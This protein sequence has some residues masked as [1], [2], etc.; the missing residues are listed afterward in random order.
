MA[1]SSGYVSQVDDSICS[2]C[3]ECVKTC[4]FLAIKVEDVAEVDRDTCLG[5]GVCIDQCP[6]EALHL[7][8]DMSKGE[9]MDVQKLSHQ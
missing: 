9:P 6:E 4:P 5:C 2:G 7:I 8:R 1:A 3:G